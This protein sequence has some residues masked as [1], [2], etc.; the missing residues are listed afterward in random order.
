MIKFQ[1]KHII[2][3]YHM[4]G[5]ESAGMTVEGRAGVMCMEVG[6]VGGRERAAVA[7]SY[8]E[9]VAVTSVEWTLVVGGRWM[10][11]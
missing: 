1:S 11:V 3:D 4:E 7:G 9:M 8:R 2:R 6:T 5:R 10:A